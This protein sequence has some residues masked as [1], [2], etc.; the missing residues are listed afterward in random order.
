MEDYVV[1]ID[2]LK[3]VLEENHF[4]HSVDKDSINEKSKSNLE[5]N[6]FYHMAGNPWLMGL[7][8]KITLSM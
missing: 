3:K 4:F 1:F 7:L 6:V 8:S 2:E 5:K